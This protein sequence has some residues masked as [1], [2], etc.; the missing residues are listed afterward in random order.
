MFPDLAG[1]K[2]LITGATGG[3]GGAIVK[4]LSQEGCKLAIS[5]TR[6]AKLAEVAA[7]ANADCQ[8][9]PA[10]LANVEEVENLCAWAVEQLGGLDILICNAGI[11]ADGLAMRMK[12]EDFEKV[13]NINLRAS[14]ILNREA[15]KLMIKQRSGK[16]VNIASVV[17]FTGNPGQANYVASK[18]GLVGMSKSLAAE[19]ASRNVNVNCIAPG[20]I[21]TPMTEV[22]T[23][24]QKENIIKM[25]PKQKMG[26]AE[27]I[28]NG[29]AFLVSAEADYITGTTLHINGGMYM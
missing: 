25:I 29:V 6:Q 20:F 7:G 15:I 11:T 23:E 3:I 1:K 10:D 24:V 12:T 5:G 2:A 19:T 26:T 14:F 9:L 4:R 13:L 18:A 17:G 28:A 16:I 21:D 27:D 22:L 8:L